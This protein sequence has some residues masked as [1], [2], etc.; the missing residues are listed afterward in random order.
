MIDPY[1]RLPP[2][3][4][5]P[6]GEELCIALVPREGVGC[7]APEVPC[8]PRLILAALSR[9]TYAPI[10]NDVEASRKMA[11][12]ERRATLPRIGR[13][14][15]LARSGHCATQASLD[16]FESPNTLKATTR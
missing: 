7:F 11:R 1:R 12:Q 3:E 8:Y 14:M 2:V 16:G 10:V 15:G 9:I 6:A 13:S 4:S 5:R